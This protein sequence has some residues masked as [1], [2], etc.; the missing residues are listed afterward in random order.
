M[1]FARIQVFN[2]GVIKDYFDRYLWNRE[3]M[4]NRREDQVNEE[5]SF[6]RRSKE[7]FFMHVCFISPTMTNTDRNVTRG[8]INKVSRPHWSNVYFLTRPVGNDCRRV[9][10]C[11]MMK[12]LFSLRESLLPSFRDQPGLLLS[13]WKI[14]FSYREFEG[15]N[16]S[17]ESS[18]TFLIE[19]S[20][21][22]SLEH[23]K[24]FFKMYTSW[25]KY[26]NISC[27]YF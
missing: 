16:H 19:S 15:R 27:R 17:F 11:R 14:R 13:I 25:L 26:I 1:K 4:K 6:Q 2:F 22:L 3:K 24:I 9:H 20:L 8:K 18:K 5:T 21:I 7:E 10:T 23:G 12:R